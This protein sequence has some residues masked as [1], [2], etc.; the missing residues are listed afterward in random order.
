MGFES[1]FT[2]RISRTAADQAADAMHKIRRATKSLLLGHV[3]RHAQL[4]RRG[5]KCPTCLRAQ[6]AIHHVSEVLAGDSFV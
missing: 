2:R 3:R 1:V 6:E 5:L 4:G